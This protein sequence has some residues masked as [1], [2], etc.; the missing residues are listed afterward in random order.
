MD[1]VSIQKLLSHNRMFIVTQ[2]YQLWDRTEIWNNFPEISY[3]E[4]II[5]LCG[6]KKCFINV[7]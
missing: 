7:V 3:S 4:V 6:M 2:D 1:S 5:E